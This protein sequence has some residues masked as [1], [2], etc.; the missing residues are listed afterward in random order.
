MID[1]NNPPGIYRIRFKG[2][3]ENSDGLYNV[4]DVMKLLEEKIG[5][6]DLMIDEYEMDEA[7]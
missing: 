7:A 1:E 5:E 6:Y 3:K 2:L 4:E